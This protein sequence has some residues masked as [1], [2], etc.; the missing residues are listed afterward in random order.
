MEKKT[1]GSF[2]AAL[3]KANGMTQKELAERLNVSDKTVSR[4]ERD[5]G[6]PDLSVIPALAEIFGVTCDELL[7][8]ERKS[9]TERVD[10]S[11]DSEPTPKGERQRQRL[12]AVSMCR[13]KTRTLIALGISA[14]GLIAAMV[15]NFGFLR[16]YIGFF[17]GTVFYLAALISQAVFLN[18]AFLSV[19]D[20]TLSSAEAGRFR[21]SVVRLAE[22]SFGLTVVLFGFSLPLVVFIGDAYVGLGGSSWLLWGAVFALAALLL[23]A[24]VCYFLNGSLLKNEVCVLREKEE[25]CYWYNHTLKKR[26]VVTLM[27]VLALT[28]AFHAFGSEMLWSPRNL[29]GGTVFDDYE[30]F[31]A[32]M[33]Q[34]VPYESSYSTGWS[35]IAEEQA[36]A[37]E[38][39][40]LIEEV[41]PPVWYDE[42]GGEISEED[43]RKRTLEDINGN[44]VCEY[45]DRNESVSTISYSP[46]EGTV[47]PITVIT[48]G[49]HYW[50]RVRAEWINRA[51]CLI[52][53]L[54]AAAVLLYYRKKRAK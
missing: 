11:E 20:G 30:S 4:W 27:W 1:I 3:R 19:S 12:M 28:L 31:I 5:D 47:L 42:N 48:N 6:A 54:E 46:K 38:P 39:D 45:I 10:A 43:A 26:C 35:T 18:S 22:W 15:G 13:Y 36:A 33:E 34:D 8:G 24:V 41:D 25:C 32:Y 51:C 2:I 17:A 29:A 53:P 37:P 9:P 44:V 50:G 14:A 23:T 7:R 40:S 52:Y 16:A 49:D 21:W